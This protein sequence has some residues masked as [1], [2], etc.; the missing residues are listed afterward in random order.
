MVNLCTSHAP[1]NPVEQLE[2]KLDGLVTL[3]NSTQNSQSHSKPIPTT[4]SR[5]SA[6][7]GYMNATIMQMSACGFPQGTASSTPI[8]NLPMAPSGLYQGVESNM[9]TTQTVTPTQD[10][11]NP[12]VFCKGMGPETGCYRAV[13][14]P[15]QNIGIANIL[16][17]R[18]K[19]KMK[20][21]FPFLVLSPSSTAERLRQERPF[22]FLSI[23]AVACHNT[24][25]QIQLGKK[26]IK[27]LAERLVV[28]TERNL[29]LLLG[30]LTYAG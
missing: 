8:P 23:M 26:L 17:S 19:K 13:E 5:L 10:E 9:S 24:T 7:A 25:Q 14:D 27:Q 1:K 16:F 11:L 12:A 22:L 15:L 3:L 6:P 20:P 18:F 28:N 21:C 30:I 4:S 2:Q 29:D